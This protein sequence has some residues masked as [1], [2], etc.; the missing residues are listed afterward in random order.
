M[1]LPS[2]LLVFIW[3]SALALVWVPRLPAE[4]P[5]VEV[6]QAT[7]RITHDGRSGTGFFV[8]R[9]QQLL[10]VTA[11][12]VFEESTLPECRL[13]LREKKAGAAAVRREL[14]LIVRQ[15]NQPLWKKHATEDVAA[16]AVELPPEIDFKPALFERILEASPSGAGGI[17]L[18]QEVWL[19]GYPAQLEAN[20]AGW[21][22]LRRGTIA[23]HP[24]A[25]VAA[26][27]TLLVDLTSFGGDSGGPLFAIVNGVPHLAGLVVG[28][29]RQTDHTVSAFEERTVHTPLGLAI[30]IQPAIIAETIRLIPAPADGPK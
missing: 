12:H 3:W 16:M 28:M 2:R 11:A 24:L 29:H 21:P 13:I 10:L 22:V 27:P 5:L 17:T 9:D 23:S 8:R 19:P 15:D 4:E 1:I 25:P 30:A 18:G 6:L 7:C 14:P 26:V 20:D